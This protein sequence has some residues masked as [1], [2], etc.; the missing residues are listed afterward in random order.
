MTRQFVIA[1]THFM[2]KNIV[3][4][5]D[6]D[7]KVAR[8]FPSVEDHDAHLVKCWNSV[9]RFAFFAAIR[10]ILYKKV[11]YERFRSR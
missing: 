8:D 6:N 10:R 5:L 2:H 1:D 3:K 4:F 9:V 11:W 7:G